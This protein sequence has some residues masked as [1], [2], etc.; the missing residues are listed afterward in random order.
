MESVSLALNS[1]NKPVVLMYHDIYSISPDESGF[2]SKGANHYKINKEI[3]ERQVK[4]IYEAK[5]PYDI[6]FSFDD[7]GSSLFNYAAPILEKYGFK[8]IF[9][10]PTAFIGNEGFLTVSQISE[11]NKRGH[12]IASHSHTH[13]ANLSE[14]SYQAHI[15]EWV[16]SIKI[17]NDIIGS[18]VSVLSIPN[19][20]Y[21]QIDKEEAEK[22]NIKTIL[23]SLP[24]K[25]DNKNIDIIGRVAITQSTD[26]NTF[27]KI[28]KNR[29]FRRNLKFRQYILDKA[30]NIIGLDNYMKIKKLLRGYNAAN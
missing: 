6:I 10:V 5:L 8:G 29:N 19:G 1:E 15:C 25:F 17:L 9:C 27:L 30:K 24:E 28:I 18:D 20:Y 4:L 21:S 11:L 23:I 22:H 3:F 26:I 12:I 2:Q 7:G 13:P 16:N 14:L